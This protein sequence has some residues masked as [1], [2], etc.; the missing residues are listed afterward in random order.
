MPNDAALGD[1]PVWDL[2]DLFPG[3]DSPELARA[4]ADA[5]AEA[6]SMRAD[7]LVGG[8]NPVR[9]R[10]RVVLPDPLGPR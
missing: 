10:M 8:K 4:I 7:L 9:I 1:M 5:Q 3:R 2:N 6:A